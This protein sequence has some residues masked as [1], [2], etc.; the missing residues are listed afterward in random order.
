MHTRKLVSLAFFNMSAGKRTWFSKLF[1]FS[2]D[3]PPQEGVGTDYDQVKNNFTIQDEIL[4]S[5]VNFES[6]AIGR[7][8]TPTLEKLRADGREILKSLGSGRDSPTQIKVHHIAVSDIFSV[9]G[10]PE[11]REAMFQAAS[12]F[13]CLEFPGPSTTP[14]QGVTDYQYDGTQG[15]ACSLAAGPATVYRNYFAPVNGQIGQTHDNQI[16]NLEG[17]LKELDALDIVKVRNG[18]TSSDDE[19]LEPLRKKIEG[20]SHD[21]RERIKGKLSIGVHSRV[22]VPFL[23]RY[24]VA[25]KVERNIVSQCFCSALAIGYSYGST[26]NWKPLAKMVLEASYEATMWATLIDQ[27]E[28]R[29]SGKV[30]LTFVG[31]GVFGNDLSWICRAIATACSRLQ[32]APLEVYVCHYAS[33]D[34]KVQRRID[35]LISNHDDLFEN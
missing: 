11:N 9:H 4:T 16:N 5:K 25:E 3:N 32:A 27:H 21:D 30:Y 15:P 14:E 8:S 35:E 17:M 13:N 28:K 10:E 33:V 7:F 26:R 24:K 1:G 23:S 12:Q 20:L 29:G 2:E 31:G 18:Y 19:L 34:R 6:Y 22:E